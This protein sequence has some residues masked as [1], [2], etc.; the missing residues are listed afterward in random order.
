M[1]VIFTELISGKEVTGTIEAPRDMGEDNL[2]HQQREMVID[3]VIHEIYNIAGFHE[4][5]KNGEFY[6]VRNREESE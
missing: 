4:L 3:T 2:I 6:R 1:K 5:K